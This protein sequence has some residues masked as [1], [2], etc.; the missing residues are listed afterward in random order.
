MAQP[1]NP[2]VAGN[3]VGGSEAFIGR[4]DVLREVV[5]VLRRPQ[6]NAIV[7]YGQ[8]RIGKTSVL[9]QLETQLPNEGPYCPVYFD[10]QDKA[11]WPLGRVLQNLAREI[12]HV[13]NLPDPDFDDRPE[14]AFREEWLPAALDALPEGCSLVMLFDEFDVLADPEAKQA[15][16]TFFPYLRGLLAQDRARLQFVFVIGRN[17]DDL[18]T[19]ALSLFKGTPAMRVSLLSETDTADLVRLS[20]RNDSLHWP[21]ETVQRVYELSNGHPFLTQQICSHVWEQAY[22]EELKTPPMMT[23]KEVDAV[24]PGALEASRNTLEWL[25]DGLPPAERVVASALAESGS[26]PIT[27]D[28]LEQLLHESGVRVVIRELQTAPELLQDWDLIEP[29]DGNEGYRFRVELLRRW[30]TE[31]KPLERVQD[32]LDRIEPVAENL[33]QAGAGMYRNRQLDEAIGLLRQAI[34]LNPNHVKASQLLADI[35]LAQGQVKEARELL[36]RLYTYQPVAARSRLIQALL[37]EAQIAESE[38]K[39]LDLYDQVLELNPKQPEAMTERK[40]IWQQRGDAALQSN[41]LE[42]ALQAY[43]EAELFGKATEI[44]Q[45]M[46]SQVLTARLREIG[47]LQENKQY[48]EALD[49]ARD[50]AYEYPEAKDRLPDLEQLE[51]KTHLADLYQRGLDALRSRNRKAALDLLAQ[52][53]ALDPEHEDVTRYLHKAFNMANSLDEERKAHQQVEVAAEKPKQKVEQPQPELWIE[54]K[55][56]PEVVRAREEEKDNM[57]VRLSPWNPLAYLHLLWWLFITPETLF[58]RIQTAFLFC[59]KKR[60]HIEAVSIHQN[61]V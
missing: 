4:A 6:D 60:T 26:G 61:D 21:D 47:T 18:D 43:Q 38:D 46:R 3:P 54:G 33:Y 36:E 10:L 40:R 50:L 12:A 13:L 56:H 25:W 42:N 29:A 48:Q 55:V 37:S 16:E 35:L 53:V 11:A 34:G 19:I 31:H 44:E 49:I 45:K 22:D 1:I 41:H 23:P 59:A 28:E 17:V 58:L 15:S 57:P 30:L 32:E 8:R 5:R 7:L 39:Q 9:Q 14:S 52:V 2:Y 20:E 51:R 27:Q 24:V